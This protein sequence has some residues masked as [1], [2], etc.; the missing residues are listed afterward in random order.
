MIFPVKIRVVSAAL[1]VWF[2]FSSFHVNTGKPKSSKSPLFII[3]R[4]R[5]ANEIWYAINLKMNGE[6]DTETPIQAFWVKKE[7]DGGIEPLTWIQKRYSYG[8]RVIDY[9]CETE[10]CWKFQFVSYR[11]RSFILKKK[12][13]QYKVYTSSNNQEIEVTRIFVQI[14]GG[15]FWVPS[16]PF[17]KLTG[18]D[19]ETGDE[20]IEFVR[21]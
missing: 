19:P 2:C 8:I 4:S 15:S 6:I 13:D 7:K 16:V 1:L 17:V 10:E 5:D 21:H 14:D 12:D 9:S 18:I 20:I 3:N 11:K